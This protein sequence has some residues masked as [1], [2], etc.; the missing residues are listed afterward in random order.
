MPALLRRN[1]MVRGD[2]PALISERGSLS[3]G[4]L[5][6]HSADIARQLVTAGVDKSS[7]VGLL[8]E[9]GI[10]WALHAS[11]I[12]RTGATLVP[13]STLLKPPELHHQLQTA[14]VTEL[15]VTPEFRGR[16]Y[17]SDLET[18][19][20]GC[21]DLT[22]SG[23]RHVRLPNLRGIWAA[24]GLPA[25][26]VEPSIVS[27]LEDTVRPSNDLVILFTS[28]SRGT[29][30]GVIHTHGGAIRATAA[31]LPSRCVGP[32]ERLYIPMPFF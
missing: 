2:V 29:P 16:S 12:M 14:A 27:A 7:R 9:N 6:T 21:A 10:E 20:P 23:Q 28:G 19:A 13:L 32:D 22:A 24:E 31:G 4:Q 18:I 30:K 15:I 17:L 26:Q 5:D 8:M 1:A 3:H 25:A 11:A